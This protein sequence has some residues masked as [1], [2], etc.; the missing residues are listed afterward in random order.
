MEFKIKGTISTGHGTSS[1]D[2]FWDY[3]I[4]AMENL[5]Y[6]FGGSITQDMTEVEDV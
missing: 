5:G 3:F 6:T 4:E 1:L 2:D